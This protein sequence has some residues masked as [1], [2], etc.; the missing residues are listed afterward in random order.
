MQAEGISAQTWF[1]EINKPKRNF[2][3]S[4]LLPPPLDKSRK[5]RLSYLD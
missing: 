4:D 3:E 5:S 1:E 2:V